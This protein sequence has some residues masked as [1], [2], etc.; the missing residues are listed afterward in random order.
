MAA[1][2]AVTEDM[3]DELGVMMMNLNAGVPQGK[4]KTGLLDTAE[5][6]FTGEDAYKWISKRLEIENESEIVQKG[7]TIFMNRNIFH[8]ISKKHTSF[9]NKDDVVY[10]FKLLEPPTEE[11]EP[12]NLLAKKYLSEFHSNPVELSSNLV[13]SITSLYEEHTS[14]GTVNFKVLE[15]SDD[16]RRFC[17]Q[18]A[19]LSKVSLEEMNEEERL[20]FFLNVYNCVYLHAIVRYGLPASNIARKSLLLKRYNVSGKNFSIDNF[21]MIL[22]GLPINDIAYLK[23]DPIVHTLMFNGTDSSPLVREYRSESFQ[24]EK[25]KA[26]KEY[27]DQNVKYKTEMDEIWLPRQ[28]KDY[29]E[30]FGTKERDI[31]DFVSLYAPSNYLKTYRDTIHIKYGE[32]TYSKIKY[33]K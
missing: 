7:Q 15:S 10:R 3:V 6:C 26:A 4:R 25:K 5:D 12:L 21:Q 23:T 8:S 16:Y 19:A 1:D 13:D 9:H 32:N 20:V 18:S 24:E 2:E 11:E 27:L 31:L 22:R 14:N 33:T 30:D 17:F 29:K 28:F